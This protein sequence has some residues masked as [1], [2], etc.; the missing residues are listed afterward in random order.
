M[1]RRGII[2]GS[3]GYRYDGQTISADLV[4]AA[5]PLENFE[6]CSRRAACGRTGEFPGEGQW[7]CEST[8]AMGHLELWT[9]ELAR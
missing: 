8:R 1:E 5:L 2:T 3:A 6:N 7:P 9:S 4:G